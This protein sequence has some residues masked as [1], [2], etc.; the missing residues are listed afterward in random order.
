MATRK[1]VRKLKL[2]EIVD[3]VI[4]KFA[5]IGES[6]WIRNSEAQDVHGCEV[7]ARSKKACSFCNLGVLHNVTP[8]GM[9]A[10][11]VEQKID[12]AW[13]TVIHYNMV[14]YND[15]SAITFGDNLAAWVKVRE[16]LTNQEKWK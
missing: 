8:K 6:K 16:E 4:L 3:R 11:S 14:G 9:N 5:Q 12:A 13:R 15:Y 1:P 10:I 2:T 7:D